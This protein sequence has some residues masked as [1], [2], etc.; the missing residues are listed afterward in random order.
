MNGTG[1]AI[2]AFMITPVTAPFACGTGNMVDDAR[3][4]WRTPDID[5]YIRRGI[6][7]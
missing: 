6:A 4:I 5:R 2:C 7:S 1:R 3:L